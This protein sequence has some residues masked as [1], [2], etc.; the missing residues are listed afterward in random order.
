MTKRNVTIAASISFII[1]FHSFRFPLKHQQ[2]NVL[3]FQCGIS[4]RDDESIYLNMHSKLSLDSQS[5]DSECFT[6]VYILVCNVCL[7]NVDGA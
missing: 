3:Q 4:N 5:E 1:T 2:N 7:I 6:E